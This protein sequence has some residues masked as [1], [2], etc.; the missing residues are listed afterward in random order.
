MIRDPYEISSLITWSNGPCILSNWHVLC[1]STEAQDGKDDISQ[2]GPQHLGSDP[3][4]IIGQLLRSTELS[5]GYD[6]AI[7]RLASDISLKN[8]ALGSDLAPVGIGEP[9]VK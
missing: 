5:H 4:R 1:G 6:A 2:P 9:A 8:E 7:A 3:P